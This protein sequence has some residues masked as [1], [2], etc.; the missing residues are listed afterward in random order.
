MHK[1]Y[2]VFY[3]IGSMASAL[4]GIL[5]Y[6]L[7]QMAGL[8]GYAGWRWIFIMEGI[9][10]CLIAIAGYFLIVG[11]PD[12]AKRNWHFLSERETKL[13]I[14]RVSKNCSPMISMLC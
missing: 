6:G 14:A 1:R 13:I 3:F 9:I 5:A 12:D 11:F 8:R 10:T 4:A 2:S 7:M